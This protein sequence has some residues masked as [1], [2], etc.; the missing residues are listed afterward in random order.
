MLGKIYS[1]FWLKFH[2]V[3][4][5]Q[6]ATMP[7]VVQFKAE[8]K[9][10]VPGKGGRRFDDIMEVTNIEPIYLKDLKDNHSQHSCDVVIQVREK[11]LASAPGKSIFTGN[12]I[13]Y[14][15]HG[16]MEERLTNVVL[17]H[18]FRFD[19]DPELHYE[20]LPS[21]PI[22]HMHLDE[23]MPE[24]IPEEYSKVRRLADVTSFPHAMG[25]VRIPT[26]RMCFPSMLCAL[27]ADYYGGQKLDELL[28]LTKEMRKQLETPCDDWAQVVDGA[29]RHYSGVHWYHKRVKKDNV[30]TKVGKR[31][32]A[33]K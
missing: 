11:Y 12:I 18:S 14:L 25:K 1:D 29:G 26:A 17:R 23:N 32:K 10:S 13:Y 8:R 28:G 27:L 3:M 7:D 19:Y 30:G 24:G 15:A 21:H 9:G 20:E 5:D 33:K 6:S 22:F 31:E 16:V 2:K 4:H